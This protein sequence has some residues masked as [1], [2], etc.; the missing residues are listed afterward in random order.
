MLLT[1]IGYSAWCHNYVGAN[2]D[3][4]VLSDASIISM[5]LW[6]RFIEP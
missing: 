3:K 1:A 6:S 4:Q 5:Q 2:R